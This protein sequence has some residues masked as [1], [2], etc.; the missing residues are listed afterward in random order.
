MPKFNGGEFFITLVHFPLH[1]L[2]C[3]PRPV[4]ELKTVEQEEQVITRPEGITTFSFFFSFLSFFFSF[5][6]F[7]CFFS[8]SSFLIFSVILGSDF[9]AGCEFD[10]FSTLTG[11]LTTFGQPVQ[12][13]FGQVRH[14]SPTISVIVSSTGYS[15]TLWT[16]NQTKIINKYFDF[17]IFHVLCDSK[18]K[19]LHRVAW[20]QSWQ[21]WVER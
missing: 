2:L 17:N 20:V 21:W 10:L 18:S 12:D 8:I 15:S 7:L 13:I 11:A 16:N 14:I 3:S 5:F 1:S 9:L 19:D 6:S 4:T